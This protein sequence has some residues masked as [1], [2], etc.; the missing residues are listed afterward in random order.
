MEASALNLL[1]LV[2]KQTL[3]F[4]VESSNVA[5]VRAVTQKVPVLE[6]MEKDLGTVSEFVVTA[7]SEGAFR[8]LH[9]LQGGIFN[10]VKWQ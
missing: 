2:T 4:S 1:G 6:T 10:L 8:D 3:T 7:N 5:A 9:W